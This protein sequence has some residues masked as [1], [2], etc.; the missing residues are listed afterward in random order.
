M[1]AGEKPFPREKMCPW[2]DG[3]GEKTFLGEKVRP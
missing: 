1:W 2:G 3:M